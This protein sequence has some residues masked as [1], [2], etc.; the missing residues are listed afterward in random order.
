MKNKLYTIKCIILGILTSMSLITELSV[1]KEWF[2]LLVIMKAEHCHSYTH[3]EEVIELANIKNM[4][5]RD[6]VEK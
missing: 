1:K 5:H 4:S 6:Y 3:I 2:P